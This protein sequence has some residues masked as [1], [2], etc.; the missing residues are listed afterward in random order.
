VSCKRG[1]KLIIFDKL[2]FLKVYSTFP[3]QQWDSVTYGNVDVDF[4]VWKR[5]SSG[6]DPTPT[7]SRRVGFQEG[8][9]SGIWQ[10]CCRRQR[11]NHF[12]A[13]Q[14]LSDEPVDEVTKSLL[15][16]DSGSNSTAKI[17]EGPL[18]LFNT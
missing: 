17:R 16:G 15:T 4:V 8:S 12:R 9:K 3:P 5:R 11:V 13:R 1:M 6:S 7:S 2:A 18:S 10:E 14:R